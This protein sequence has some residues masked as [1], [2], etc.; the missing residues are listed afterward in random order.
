MFFS[1]SKVLGLD[2][3]S[4]SIKIAELDVSK[5]GARLI[6]FGMIQ[7]PPNSIN[8]GDVTDP[9]SLA[10]AVKS[11]CIEAKARRKSACVGMFGT[12]VIVKKITIPRID[13]K[14]VAEQARWEAEQYIPFDVNS[15]SLAHHVINPREDT[16]T[17]DI[18]L[19]AA[20]NELVS[21]YFQVVQMAGLKMGI[22][23]VSAF[24]LANIFEFNYGRTAAGQAVGLL[25]LGSAI[26]N[27]VVVANG[28]VVFSR[29]MPIGGQNYTTDIHKEMGVS[30]QEAESLK[31]S[32]AA[33]GGVPDDVHSVLSSTS[34][35]VTEEIRNSFDFFA[36]SSG[37]LNISRVYYTGGAAA[38]P[39]L[40]RK[41]S[42]ATKM[43]HEI[44]NPFVRISSGNKKISTMYIDQITP[45]CAVS[46]G[47]GLRKIG[48]R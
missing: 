46:L 23:D 34:E 36:G 29:D 19:I 39:G 47:L 6:N 45:F 42:Q 15:I 30:L 32:A 5:G 40:I 10:V 27:F 22:L 31:L 14:L 35:M 25:N 33:G 7:T 9:N 26:T 44:L 43:N 20:Q 41:L 3:G 16:E 28:E 12:A 8:G 1:A 24:A 48:D 18:L 17:M 13:L 11:V 37:G 2:I 38:T 4:S 21:E